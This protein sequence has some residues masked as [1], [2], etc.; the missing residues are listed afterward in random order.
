MKRLK[1]Y[2][3]CDD[4]EEVYPFKKDF[5]KV[6]LHIKNLV[7]KANLS[8]GVECYVKDK[9]EDMWNP[10]LGWGYIIYPLHYGYSNINKYRY[11]ANKYCYVGE[12]SNH[13]TNKIETFYI[14]D[15]K[16]NMESIILNISCNDTKLLGCELDI[17]TLLECYTLIDVINKSSWRKQPYGI[18]QYNQWSK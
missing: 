2:K 12:V 11:L 6:F 17:K 14:Y 8:T 5:K 15:I 3:E 10:E 9:G 13:F 7:E 16:F 1:V 4:Y 18:G